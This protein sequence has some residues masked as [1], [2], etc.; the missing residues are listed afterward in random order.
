MAVTN[1]LALA[2]QMLLFGAVFEGLV[3]LIGYVLR[4]VLSMFKGGGE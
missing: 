2:S 1:L 4:F 3:I